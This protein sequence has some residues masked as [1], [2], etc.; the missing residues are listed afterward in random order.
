MPER[1][2]ILGASGLVGGKVLC[3]LRDN[4]YVALGA[5]RKKTGDQ[6]VPFDLL[7]SATYTAAL[8]GISTVMLISRPGDEDAAQHAAPF[9]DAM[10][11]AGV[12]RVVDLSALGAAGRPDF[13]TRKVEALLET[14]G[15]QWTHVR[16]NFFMQMLTRPP[17][18]TEIATSNTLHLPLGDAAIAYVDACDVAAVLYKALTD[19]T[20]VGRAM[21]VSGPEAVTHVLR[22]YREKSGAGSGPWPGRDSRATACDVRRKRYGRIGADRH[23]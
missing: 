22:R 4:G 1:I 23:R 9:I 5:S 8:A 18:S 10:V 16:P 6:W 19:P 7:D 12:K 21:E 13:S 17:L 15:L 2:L 3:L 20:L 11:A 14:S